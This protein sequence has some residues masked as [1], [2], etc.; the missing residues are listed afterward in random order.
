MT[1]KAKQYGTLY[2]QRFIA[3][4]LKRG[5]HVSEAKGDY[6][7]Y[8]LVVDSGKKLYRIQV[9]GTQ[10]KQKPGTCEYAV[11]TAMGA[12]TS[13]KTQYPKDSYDLLAIC[14]DTGDARIWY[15][16]PKDK[17]GN[18]LSVKLFPNPTSKGQWEKYRHGWDLIC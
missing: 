4:A 15:L 7:P 16:I 9:K 13:K 10:H 2:E 11:T 12:K 18:R 3:E 6:M 8:D 14:V 1:S 17:I 5:L